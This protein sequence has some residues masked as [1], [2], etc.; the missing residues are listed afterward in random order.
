MILIGKVLLDIW[1]PVSDLWFFQL[2]SESWLKNH[3][4]FHFLSQG[5]EVGTILGQNQSIYRLVYMYLSGWAAV[6]SEFPNHFFSK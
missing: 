3:S 2:T 4:G 5:F 6:S 1:H